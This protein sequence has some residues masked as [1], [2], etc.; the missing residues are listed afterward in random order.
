[1]EA[2]TKNAEKQQGF[3]KGRS[4][5]DAVFII[6]QI[7]EKATEFNTYQRTFASQT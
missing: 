1:M 3:L 7:K 6:K 4:I 5:T 2:Q